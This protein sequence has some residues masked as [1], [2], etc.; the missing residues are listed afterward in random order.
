MHLIS[1]RTFD[2]GQDCA[3][4]SCIAWRLLPLLF[5]LYVVAFLDRVNVVCGGLRAVLWP[6][7]PGR[8]EWLAHRGG[9]PMLELLQ[10]Q[11]PDSDALA[12]QK[13]R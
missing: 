10:A 11:Q 8:P 2:N 1:R 9:R 4:Y 6:G 7:H 5:V 12:F 3:L 13:K